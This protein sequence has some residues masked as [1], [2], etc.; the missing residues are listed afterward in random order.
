M[1]IHL[2]LDNIEIKT[3][4]LKIYHEELNAVQVELKNDSVSR[5]VQFNSE[6]HS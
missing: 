2:Y 5:K 4:V 6:F 1:C 3:S